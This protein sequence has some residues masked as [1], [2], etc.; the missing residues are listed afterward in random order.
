MMV[1]D[2]GDDVLD[3]DDEGRDRAGEVSASGDM[4]EEDST[5]DCS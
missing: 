1:E 3:A 4:L 5:A 2:D